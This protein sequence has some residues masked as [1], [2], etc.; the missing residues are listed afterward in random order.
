MG[1]RGHPILRAFNGRLAFVTL[2][3]FSSSINY[4][5]DIIAFSSTQALDAFEEKFGVFDPKKKTWIIEPYFLSL[6]NSLTY[7]GQLAGV[8]LGGYVNNR[9]GRRM[10]F[11]IMTL[12]AWLGAI[13]LVTAQVKEQMLAG[14]IINYVYQGMEIV[15]IPVMQAEICPA[16]LRGAVVSSYWIG[17]LIGSLIMS[18]VVYGTKHIEGEASFR[19]PFGIFFI[20]PTLVF[21]STRWMTESPRWLLTQDRPEE[22]LIS[23]RKYRQG[24]FT[25]DEIM[26]EYAEQVALISTTKARG[27]LKELFQGPNRRRTIIAVLFNIILQITG[28][29]FV[30]KYGTIFLKDIKAVD[31][32]ALNNINSSLYIV[33]T[34]LCMYLC[35]HK[36]FGRKRLLLI[37]S[38][39]QAGALLALAGIG[40]HRVMS[41]TDGVA[42]SSLLTIS[43]F[44][45]CF[46]WGPLSHAVTAEIP[47]PHLRNYTYALSSSG[48]VLISFLVAFTVPYLYYEPY[49]ALGPKIGFIYGGGAVISF[50]FVWFCIPECRGLTLEEVDHLFK[51]ATPIREFSK[52]K[53][54]AVLP[55]NV[56]QTLEEKVLVPA[57]HNETTLAV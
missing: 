56:K 15:S 29:A 14:R 50:A 17:I 44:A 18:L 5:L 45:F 19:I 8:L 6:L 46:G 47:S 42:I 2:I 25:E 35:E 1:I 22:A 48:N 34:G 41:H 27:T 7:V 23:L 36:L 32:F 4:G 11:R 40:T 26:E 37:S 51:Q 9:W 30:I 10:S 39:V 53:T 20:V 52:H 12:W 28:N 24:N 49:A 54:G 21:V 43:Y 16:Q 31:P 13:L 57:I 55:V 38:V 3:L 33:A